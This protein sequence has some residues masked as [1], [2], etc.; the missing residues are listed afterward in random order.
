MN[1]PEGNGHTARELCECNSR[2]NLYA[3]RWSLILASNKQVALQI[4]VPQHR[5][6]PLKK[7]WMEVYS[8]VTG[9]LK[10]DMRMNLKTRK[11]LI[12]AGFSAL[13]EIQWPLQLGENGSCKNDFDM[14]E[15]VRSEF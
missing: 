7:S 15:L 2:T 9:N 10:L 4:P 14:L 13:Q 3:K 6:T 11:V 12:F 5:L 8:T 1:L